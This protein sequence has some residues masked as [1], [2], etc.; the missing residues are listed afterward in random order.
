[1]N[2][3]KILMLDLETTSLNVFDAKIW[4]VGAVL[5]SFPHFKVIEAYEYTVGVLPEDWDEETLEW[6][7]KT[8]PP[9]IVELATSSPLGMVK[10]AEDFISWVERLDLKRTII[11]CNHP[12]YDIS[13]LKA[14]LPTGYKLPWSHRNVQDLQ[15]VIWGLVHYNSSIFMSL[16][17]A[18]KNGSK[19]SHRAVQDC[20]DQIEWLQ[21]AF[22][23]RSKQ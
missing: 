8:Y 7:K 6:A 16:S 17:D 1:M 5:V 11:M 13:V 15:S 22:E 10:P 14:N 18:L 3:N 20:L 4:E 21:S 19:T 9:H 2:F 23:L 12:E